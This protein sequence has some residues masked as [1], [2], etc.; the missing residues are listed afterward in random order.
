[1]IRTGNKVMGSQ[2]LH[3]PICILFILGF[4]IY[5]L[6]CLS[7]LP[8]Q[9]VTSNIVLYHTCVPFCQY[10]KSS[11]RLILDSVLYCIVLYCIVLYCIVLYCIV[12][13]CIVLYCIVL[14]CIVLYCI[15]LYCITRPYTDGPIGPLVCSILLIF[16]KFSRPKNPKVLRCLCRNMS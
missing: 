1:M 3:Y 13:Y 9:Y 14:Y 8:L 16:N 5:S 2:R 6:L 10:F 7:L 12:L 15:V 11:Y 4:A